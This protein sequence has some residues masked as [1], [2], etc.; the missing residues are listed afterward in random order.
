MCFGILISLSSTSMVP[1]S[2]ALNQAR[3]WRVVVSFIVFNIYRNQNKA[4]FCF[5]FG[6]CGIQVATVF[7][8]EMVRMCVF[9]EYAT[10]EG[11]FAITVSYLST[12]I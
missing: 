5:G 9:V 10:C 7:Q 4:E 3:D 8:L 1:E 12:K 6:L 2:S 11:A